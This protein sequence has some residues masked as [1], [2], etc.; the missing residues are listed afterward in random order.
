[1][2]AMLYLIVIALLLSLSKGATLDGRVPSPCDLSQPSTYNC[3]PSC[4]IP[5]RSERCL[6]Q[7]K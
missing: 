3:L 5:C 4:R 1:M 7:C 6:Y 2:Y